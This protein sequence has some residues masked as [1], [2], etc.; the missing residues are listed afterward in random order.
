MASVLNQ[1]FSNVF[2]VENNPRPAENIS[3]FTTLDEEMLSINEVQTLEVRKL[4]LKIH[5]NDSTDSDD[6][7]PRMLK[8]PCVL[9]ECTIKLLYMKIISLRWTSLG[10]EN[11][12][13]LHQSSKKRK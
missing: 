3:M 11:K 9:L 4:L 8:E 1:T 12:Q 5:P 10:M 7:S 6:I 13:T 2:I